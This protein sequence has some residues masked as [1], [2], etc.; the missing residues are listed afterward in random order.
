MYFVGF[1]LDL[2]PC[3]VWSMMLWISLF[4]DSKLDE[5]WVYL[6]GFCILEMVFVHVWFRFWILEMG[7]ALRKT[8]T[9]QCNPLGR[10]ARW[11]RK[12]WAEGRG[13]L[14]GT[15]SSLRRRSA[16]S[17]VPLWCSVRPLGVDFQ[18]AIL[19]LLLSVVG[20]CF[21]LLLDCFVGYFTMFLEYL[22]VLIIGY[23]IP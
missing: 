23:F 6:V 16:E 13:P 18:W 7:L 8:R 10:S 17:C 2:L 22:F 12:C 9:A 14:R 11:Q 3:V 4:L 19:L 21:R 15:V 20:L 1:H 5:M